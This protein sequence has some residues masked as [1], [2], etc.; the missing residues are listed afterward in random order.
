MAHLVDPFCLYQRIASHLLQAPG[1]A[2]VEQVPEALYG[3]FCHQLRIG[4]LDAYTEPPPRR[5]LTTKTRVC[6]WLA[7]LFAGRV[8]AEWDAYAPSLIAAVLADTCD[9]LVGS[10]AFYQA[11]KRAVAIVNARF[12]AQMD[13]D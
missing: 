13:V 6:C 7:L 1:L 8:Q 11:L 2:R 9:E 3:D 10:H 4:N 5:G 12:V